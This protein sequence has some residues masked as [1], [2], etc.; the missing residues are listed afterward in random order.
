MIGAKGRV[1]Y[2]RGQSGATIFDDDHPIHINKEDC[3]IS[4]ICIWHVSPLWYLTN[5]NGIS[6]SLVGEYRDYGKLK[7][8]SKQRITSIIRDTNDAQITITCKGVFNEPIVLVFADL[9]GGVGIVSC[10]TTETS[11]ELRF[12]LHTYISCG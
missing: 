6:Y 8:V 7:S 9:G 4:K 2:T 10:W 3:G 1:V 12:I 5:S 11:N